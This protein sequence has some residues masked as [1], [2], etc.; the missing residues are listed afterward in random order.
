MS[1]SCSIR[2]VLL[3]FLALILLIQ[4]IACSQSQTPKLP[5]SKTD[6]DIAGH[7]GP[8]ETVVT[9][10][11]MFIYTHSYDPEGHLIEQTGIIKRVGMP[12]ITRYTYDETGRRIQEVVPRIVNGKEVNLIYRQ[13]VYT[14]DEKGHWLAYVSA[15]ANGTFDRATFYFYD[16]KGNLASEVNYIGHELVSR[17]TYEHDTIGNVTR[18]AHY[19][20]VDIHSGE[21]KKRP[22]GLFYEKKNSY[23][24]K[25]RRTE[26]SEYEPDGK[27][28]HREISKYDARGNIVERTDYDVNGQVLDK[29]ETSYEYD[30]MGNWLKRINRTAIN[31]LN[32]EGKPTFPKQWVTERTISYHH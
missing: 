17:T 18:E 8:V 30:S 13:A 29:V 10:D 19:L 21:F 15:L 24:S 7:L 2:N 16:L 27:L 31:P 9:D 23:D 25:G 14:Y 11:S 4:L 5:S 20:N 32:G 26:S 1:S 22:L 3:S 12:H 6:R 28:A